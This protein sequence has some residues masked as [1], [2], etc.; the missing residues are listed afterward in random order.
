MWCDEV[1]D[2]DTQEDLAG[3]MLQVAVP[4]VLKDRK[5]TRDRL[6]LHTIGTRNGL[7]CVSFRVAGMFSAMSGT[8]IGWATRPCSRCSVAAGSVYRVPTRMSYRCWY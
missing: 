2:V 1:F 4:I 7:S 5:Q 3:A 6:D 8:D